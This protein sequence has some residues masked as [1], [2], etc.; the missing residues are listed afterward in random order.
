MPY[1]CSRFILFVFAA[2]FIPVVLFS[3]SCT[4]KS[5]KANNALKLK[6]EAVDSLF[7][8]GDTYQANSL[9]KYIRN[10]LDKKSPQLS[11]YYTIMSADFMT[12]PVEKNIYADSALSFFTNETNIK[13]YPDEY[14]NAL[15]PGYKLLKF[16][17]IWRILSLKVSKAHPQ[18]GSF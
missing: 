18:P 4:Q 10:Q 15:L 17:L 1:T 11:S 13:G 5:G 14:F 2:I 8:A 7:L 9:L 12:D 3:S 6:L 16:I